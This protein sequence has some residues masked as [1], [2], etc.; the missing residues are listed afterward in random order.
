MINY[1]EGE[2]EVTGNYVK[3]CLDKGP[4]IISWSENYAEIEEAYLEKN[5]L[6]SAVR[7]SLPLE[8]VT[9]MTPEEFYDTFVNTTGEVCI[10][11]PLETWLASKSGEFD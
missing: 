10:E 1:W 9:G 2:S 4:N 7:P 11:T 8:D 6:L 5:Y 3:I